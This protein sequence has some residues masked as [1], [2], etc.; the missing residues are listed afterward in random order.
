MWII[1]K[2]FIEFVT[3]LLLFYV[4]VFWPQGMW[5]L[6]S[7]IRDRT[8]TPCIER[9]SFNHWTAREVPKNKYLKLVET[10]LKSLLPF[11]STCLCEIS[12]STMSV[13]KTKCINYLDI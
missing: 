5:D 7:P 9:Q 1:C 8:R 12:F 3:V 2:I 4:L 10:A 11:L 6:S 13:M